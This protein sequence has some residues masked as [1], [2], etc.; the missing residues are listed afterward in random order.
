MAIPYVRSHV[1]G[2]S[3]KSSTDTGL[4]AAVDYATQAVMGRGGDRLEEQESAT[5]RLEDDPRF[6]E[7]LRPDFSDTEFAS[8]ILAEGSASAQVP[9]LEALKLR[10]PGSA[11]STAVQNR[12]MLLSPGEDSPAGCGGRRAEYPHSSGSYS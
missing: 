10:K 4:T 11:T 12:L 7:F 1:R 9:L 2:S 6:V 8:R 5:L 3:C